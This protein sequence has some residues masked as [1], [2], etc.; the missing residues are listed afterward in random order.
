MFSQPPWGCLFAV[1]AVAGTTISN[2][3][4]QDIEP[5]AYASSPV[6]INFLIAGYAYSE[7]GLMAD[8]A[9]PLE[10]GQLDVH[11][12]VLAYVRSL[13]AWGRSS[14]VEVV[15]PYADVSGSA[16]YAGELRTRDV[17]GAGDP[18]LRFTINLL[19]GPARS[20]EEFAAQPPATTLGASVQLVIPAGQY[21]SSRL[22]NI[23]ANRWAIK[24][25]LGLSRPSGPLSLEIAGGVMLYGDNDEFLNGQTR[26]QKEIYSLQGHLIYQLGRPG[27]WMALSATY[28]RGGRTTVGGAENDDLQENTRLGAAFALPLS[29]NQS[30]KLYASTGV[31]TRIGTD[32]DTAGIAW[33]VR[34]GGGL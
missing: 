30:I 6:G 33:Q 26:E 10:D 9:L 4:A 11:A 21:D 23:G 22:I 16:R 1:V 25:E 8:A 20:L 14:K 12:V 2:S 34:W 5:R 28:Y 19:G 15:L 18:R 7:G 3:M 17:S 13:D 31:A 27:M 32:F 29:R 24:G